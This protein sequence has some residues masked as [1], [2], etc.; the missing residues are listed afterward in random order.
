[1]SAPGD[2]ELP[3]R[4]RRQTIRLEKRKRPNVPFLIRNSWT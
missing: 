2:H 4:Y 3:L 1:M